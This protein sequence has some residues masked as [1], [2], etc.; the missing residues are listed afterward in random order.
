MEP[1][2]IYLNKLLKALINSFVDIFGET[3][4]F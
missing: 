2:L 1:P 3:Y 4:I